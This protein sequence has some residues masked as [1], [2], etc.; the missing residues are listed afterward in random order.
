MG[1][2]RGVGS[3]CSVRTAFP[4]GKMESSRDQFHSN[5]SIFDTPELY[6]EKWYVFLPMNKKERPRQPPGEGDL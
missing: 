3:G 1:R 6:T 2:G 4:F 5:V